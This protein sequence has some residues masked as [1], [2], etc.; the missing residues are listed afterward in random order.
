MT[1]ALNISNDAA[2][3]VLASSSPRRRV[4]LAMLQVPV[5]VIPADLDEAELSRG[6]DPLEAAVLLAKAKASAVD[7]KGR[8]VLGADTVVSLNGEVLGKPTDPA[9]G[10]AMLR[11]QFSQVVQ[12]ISCVALRR[13]NGDMDDRVAIS[14]LQVGEID[15][16][17]LAEYLS[18]GEADD[19]AGALA[20]Q[21]GAKAFT[22]L[23]DGSRSNVV[24]LPL[25]E[26]IELL[27]NAGITVHDPSDD[28]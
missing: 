4:L 26:T 23:V 13:P 8:P 2:P 11:R 17:S 28:R 5:H 1:D 21:G 20:V 19:K 25:T 15:D 10:E 16:A 27:R 9:H 7:G 22:T 6:L 24:G 12:V 3:L 18:S 14:T